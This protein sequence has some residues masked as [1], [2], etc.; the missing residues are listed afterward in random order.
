M[1]FNHFI[2]I[3]VFGMAGLLI[4]GCGRKPRMD[5][6]VTHSK[7]GMTG[8][9]IFGSI[10]SNCHSD[11]QM[12]GPKL[13]VVYGKPAMTDPGF[14]DKY[15]TALKLSTPGVVWGRDNLR[16]LLENPQEL[17]PGINMPDPN[18]DQESID[19]VINYLRNVSD[20]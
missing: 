3:T 18:L 12:V 13:T 1:K 9:G 20:S 11:R 7:T 16:K 8:E 17:L 10:C 6:S 4:F 5:L 15:S 19:L 2:K 14:T